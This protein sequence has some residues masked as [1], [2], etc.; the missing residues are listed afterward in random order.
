MTP[1]EDTPARRR[2]WL[3][4]CRAIP[5]SSAS[6]WPVTVPV[7]RSSACFEDGFVEVSL[8]YQMLTG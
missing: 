4:R 1:P 8:S 6:S 3:I 7:H 2:I 5:N